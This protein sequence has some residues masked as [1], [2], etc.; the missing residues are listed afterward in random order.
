MDGFQETAMIIGKKIDEATEKFSRAV[1]VDLDIANKRDKTNEELR[2]L[3]NLLR[4][5]RHKALIAIGRDHEMT[6][7][8]FTLENDEKEY[9]VKTLL[10]GGL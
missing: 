7:V 10:S 3:P 9:F 1:G 4:T 2:K 8:F 5:E 6:A